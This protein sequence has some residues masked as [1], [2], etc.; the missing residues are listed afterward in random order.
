MKRALG[1]DN[2]CFLMNVRRCHCTLDCLLTIHRIHANKHRHPKLTADSSP[3]PH[4]FQPDCS[5]DPA[6]PSLAS[7]PRSQV[8][9]RPPRLD[10][11]SAIAAS[12]TKVFWPLILSRV[13]FVLCRPCTAVARQG[14]AVESGRWRS[15]RENARC[16][17]SGSEA[18][19]GIGRTAW[20][21]ASESRDGVGRRS[22]R[23]EAVRF[24][25]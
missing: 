24:A 9:S 1:L 15:R 22:N 12:R 19:G 10:S 21:V 14:D 2:F 4:R 6:P 23:S 18:R 7:S 17:P 11:C 13:V 25:F 16:A 5:I 20:E 3:R 8:D